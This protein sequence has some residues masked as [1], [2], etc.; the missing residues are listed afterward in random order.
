[1]AEALRMQG[2]RWS[3]GTHGK[4]GQM[5]KS[6]EGSRVKTDEN[7]FRISAEMFASLKALQGNA[8]YLSSS[9]KERKPQ[10]VKVASPSHRPTHGAAEWRRRAVQTQAE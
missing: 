5:E 6:E 7:Y 2:G 10:P 4:A 1:M 9:S 3:L 8:T